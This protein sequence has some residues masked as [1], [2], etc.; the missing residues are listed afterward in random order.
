MDAPPKETNAEMIKRLEQRFRI[1]K[2]S[3]LLY[4]R[5]LERAIVNL[6][7]ERRQ[8]SDRSSLD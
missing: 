4:N 1:P 5:F 7:W 2:Y 8:K 3:T 6:I